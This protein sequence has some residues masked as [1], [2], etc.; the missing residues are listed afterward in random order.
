MILTVKRYGVFVTDFG[1]FKHE[2]WMGFISAV[3]DFC[4]SVVFVN[5]FYQKY[6]AE[7]VSAR[8][9]GINFNV[10]KDIKFKH[11]YHFLE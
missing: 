9:R 4:F 1:V 6:L 11:Y 8:I 7:T 3:V 2:A 10:N 5:V